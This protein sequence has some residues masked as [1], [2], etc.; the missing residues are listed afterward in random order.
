MRTKFPSQHR[1]RRPDVSEVWGRLGRTSL[2]TRARGWRRVATGLALV[3]LVAVAACEP[4]PGGDTSSPST[5]VAPGTSSTTSTSTTSPSTSTT[6]TSTTTTSTTTTTIPDPGPGGSNLTLQDTG[7]TRV[8][9]VLT[10]SAS[11]VTVDLMGTNM[12]LIKVQSVSG[13]LQLTGLGGTLIAAHGQGTAVIDFVLSVPPGANTWLKMC[14]NYL[15]P[16]SVTVTRLT[17]GETVVSSL[18]NT[19]DSTVVAP[20]SC[21]NYRTGV[22]TRSD[23]IGPARWPARRDPRPL[24]LAN[25]YPW[26]DELEL[27]QDF[28]DQPVGPADTTD[29]VQVAQTVATAAASGI[30]GFVVEYEGS[31]PYDSRIDLV[32]D[33][34]DARPGFQMAMML[35]FAILQYR[36]L[37]LSSA[38]LDA[39]LDAAARHVHRP[40]QLEVAGQPVVFLYSSS[41]L[42]PA[43]WAAALSRLHSR[44]GIL[45]FVIDDSDAM[46]G[47]GQYA[48]GP[49][50]LPTPTALQQWSKDRLMTVQEAPGLYGL[51]GPLWVAPVSP[52]ADDSRV[53][54]P[55]TVV[56][57]ANGLRYEQTWDAALASLPDWILVSTWNEYYEQ[58]H[59]APGSTT[60]YLALDQTRARSAVF[61]TTG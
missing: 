20:G 45:P 26:Y 21:E 55:A 23:L 58:T 54:W 56:P 5:T 14:K 38:G 60:G 30:D 42:D 19:G 25:Y 61:H 33:A 52:G 9:V 28:G 10:S 3:S 24:V 34:A 2:L 11:W 12:D 44:T 37:G 57:R 29:P 7:L 32:W 27:A 31:P 39:A 16:A 35:D 36:P 18:N 51:A 8:R 15:G 6:S 40:S 46:P 13:S 43:Q 1:W 22:M 17:Y 50:H 4:E 41:L 48:Y 47:P 59:V 49:N 53:R